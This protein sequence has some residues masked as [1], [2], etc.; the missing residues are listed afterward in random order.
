MHGRQTPGNLEAE[1][2]FNYLQYFVVCHS[3]VPKYEARTKKIEL[4]TSHH[5]VPKPKKRP[6]KMPT[7][8]SPILCETNAMGFPW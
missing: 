1:N 4:F 5:G 6:A 8:H 3:F 7:G 2:A